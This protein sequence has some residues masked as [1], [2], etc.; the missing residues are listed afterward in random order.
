MQFWPESDLAVTVNRFSQSKKWR[1]SLPADLRVPMV[2]V[3]GQHFYVYEPAQLQDMSIVVPVFFY[4]DV[5][6]LRAR[7]L[8]ATEAPLFC[9]SLLI[10]PEP[11][12]HSSDFLDVNIHSLAASF[13]RIQQADG[14][15][16]ASSPNSKLL[17]TC[18]WFSGM[19]LDTDNCSGAAFDRG[20]RR[21]RPGH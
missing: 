14:Q 5:S 6:G 7:C 11:D 12:F 20:P 19:S 15:M 16:W 3:D 8:R 1:E 18:L 2:H 17:R 9:S 10:P 4:R 21:R 13:P